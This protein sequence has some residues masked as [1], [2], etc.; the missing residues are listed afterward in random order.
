MTGFTLTRL[1]FRGGVWQGRF[2]ANSKASKVPK[3]ELRSQGEVIEGVQLQADGKGAW[4]IS[5]PIPARLLGDGVAGFLI[6]DAATG[7]ELA[8]F[9]IAAGIPADDDLRAEIGLLRAEL[10]LLKK[11]FR[12]HVSSG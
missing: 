3:V 4:L 6:V 10:E 12:R 5:A 8:G 9:S 7:A 2:A 11:A 1:G